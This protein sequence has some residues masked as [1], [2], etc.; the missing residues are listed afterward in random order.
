MTLLEGG[1][2]CVQ[3][4]ANPENRWIRLTVEG[5]DQGEAILR[6][7]NGADDWHA[8]NNLDATLWPDR[9]LCKAWIQEQGG[10]L[11]LPTPS[12]TNGN[13]TLRLSALYPNKPT[14]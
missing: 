14:H 13:I 3:D 4:D 9:T 6:F 12:D 7:S 8:C 5:S 10:T 2:L 1:R 11:S